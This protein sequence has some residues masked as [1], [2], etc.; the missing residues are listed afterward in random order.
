METILEAL[1]AEPLYIVIAVVFVG[2]ILYSLIKKVIKL[3]LFLLLVLGVYLGYLGWTGRE[4]PINGENLKD[5]VIQDVEKAGETLKKKSGEAI[6]NIKKEATESLKK[7]AE[8]RMQNG[9][10]NPDTTPQKTENE[11]PSD[12]SN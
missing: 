2:C 6:N 3:A 7:E 8:K 5:A 9:L 11:K 4:L 10:N 1:M 12:E